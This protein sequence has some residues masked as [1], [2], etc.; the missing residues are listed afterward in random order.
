MP[1]LEFS[2]GAPAPRSTDKTIDWD[3][4]TG[5]MLANDLALAARYIRE[6]HQPWARRIRRQLKARGSRRS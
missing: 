5:V 1:Q 4:V 6:V 2:F 3:S